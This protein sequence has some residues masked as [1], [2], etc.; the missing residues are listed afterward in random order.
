MYEDEEFNR[1]GKVTTA[2]NTICN[3]GKPVAGSILDS[4]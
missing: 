4:V 2:K 3:T 1:A